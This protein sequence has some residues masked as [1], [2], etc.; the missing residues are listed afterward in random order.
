[1][2]L[3][4]LSD[5]Y[6]PEEGV[7]KFYAFSGGNRISFA[8]NPELAEPLGSVL[9]KLK[10]LNMNVGDDRYLNLDSLQYRVHLESK[11]NQSQYSC[12]KVPPFVPSLDGEN[13]GGI[14]YPEELAS[15]VLEAMKERAGLYL[16]SGS[17]GTGKSTTAAAL[18]NFFLK[19]EGGVGWAL[20]NPPE[21]D[22]EGEYGD[23]GVGFQHEVNNGDFATSIRGMMRNYPSGANALMLIGEVR[24]SETAKEVLKALLNGTRVIFTFHSGDAIEAVS[25]FIQMCDGGEDARAIFA[26]SLRLLVSQQT[27]IS[28][29]NQKKLNFEFLVG[30]SAVKAAIAQGKFT[31]LKDIQMSQKNL[32][33]NA[34]KFILS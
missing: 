21:Y 28:L 31:S 27:A 30:D 6:L 16:I 29:T 5:V 2:E 23:Q 11:K 9:E 15:L 22:L 26:Q 4:D 20:E 13:E 19:K 12:R 7:E 14:S 3:T 34:H 1:M 25:R 24:D 33:N 10:A 8:S 18:F 17:L 32:R